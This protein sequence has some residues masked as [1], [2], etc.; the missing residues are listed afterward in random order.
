MDTNFVQKKDKFE[1][2]DETFRPKNLNDFQEKTYG[3]Q[4]SI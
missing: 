4:Y 2:T 3:V 1:S